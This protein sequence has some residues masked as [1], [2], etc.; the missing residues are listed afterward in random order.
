MATGDYGTR[1]SRTSINSAGEME[2]WVAPTI[3]ST[4][5]YFNY[6]VTVSTAYRPDKIS[7]E[8]YGNVTFDWVILYVNGITDPFKELKPGRV[9]KVPTRDSVNLIL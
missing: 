7:Y 1:F 2:F 9:L 6:I 3:P 8:V 5:S 4:V